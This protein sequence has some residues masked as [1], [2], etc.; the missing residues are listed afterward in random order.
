MNEVRSS[1][2]NPLCYYKI[3]DFLKDYINKNSIIV[4]VGT[5]KCIGDCLGPL[6][7][8][9]LKFSSFP[10]PVYGTIEKPIHA[11]NIQ[12][13]LSKIK[14]L[15]PYNNIIGIDA[16]LGDESSMGEI[17]ARDYPIHPGKGIG[18]TLPEIGDASII[19][20]VGSNYN[21]KI[22]NNNTIRLN[23]V[24]NIAKEIYH[25]VIHSYYLYDNTK[26]SL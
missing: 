1:Y 2:K 12:K 11:L 14:S 17:Q 21:T 4:C 6:V 3:A 18:K 16:C 25:S 9:L 24:L 8:T 15:H 26:S 20:I 5:D 19:G 22:F 23:L 10:L 13:K 7:G